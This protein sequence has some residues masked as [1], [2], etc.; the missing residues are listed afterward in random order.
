MKDKIKLCIAEKL[1]KVIDKLQDGDEDDLM[2]DEEEDM[3]ED[4][5]KGKMKIIVKATKKDKD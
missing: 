2:E 5:P 3:F 1:L 4:K